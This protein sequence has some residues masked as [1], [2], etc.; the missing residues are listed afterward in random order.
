MGGI[1]LGIDFEN[2]GLSEPP[3]VSVR[4]DNQTFAQ[5]PD[6]ALSSLYECASFGIEPKPFRIAKTVYKPFPDDQIGD[7]AS[8][9]FYGVFHFFCVR[10]PDKQGRLGFDG[11]GAGPVFGDG[12]ADDFPTELDELIR[13]FVGNGNPCFD[14][15]AFKIPLHQR[16]PEFP[17]S[18]LTTGHDNAGR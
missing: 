9:H 15:V 12:A 11:R 1:H 14:H 10:V 3:D 7:D 18:G 8:R 6:A 2:P 5:R 16:P 13:A 17:V 4:H